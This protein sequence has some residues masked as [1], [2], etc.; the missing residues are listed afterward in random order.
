MRYLFVLLAWV[1]LG[2]PCEAQNVIGS[3]VVGDVKVGG[4]PPP[5]YTG[6]ADIVAFTSSAGNYASMGWGSRAISGACAASGTCKIWNVCASNGTSCADIFAATDGSPNL[7]AA[8]GTIGTCTTG[9]GGNP[10][11]IQVAYDMT[12]NSACNTQS[13]FM[14]SATGCHVFQDTAANRPTV[15]LNCNGSGHPCM[16]CA[17]GQTLNSGSTSG[18]S[19]PTF[20]PGTNTAPS[21]MAG[22][23]FVTTA[24]GNQDIMGFN[25]FAVQLIFSSS[26]SVGSTYGLG[27]YA[28]NFHVYGVPVVAN[29]Y[30]AIIADLNDTATSNMSY[31]NVSGNTDNGV[32]GTAEPITNAHICTGNN[33]LI[34]NVLEAWL[35]GNQA[36]SGATATSLMANMRGMGTYWGAY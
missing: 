28:N 24:S 19:G 3:G 30:Y 22:A 26:V 11:Q 21:T 34:G 4:G 20:L 29:T 18:P 15:A 1:V 27:G 23:A 14:G 16:A 9:G 6:P 7:A 10:C 12:G 25:S 8:S 5:G 36:I 35:W 31:L 32:I 17:S 13:D 33:Q 2:V